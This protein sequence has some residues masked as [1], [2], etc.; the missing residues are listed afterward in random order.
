MSTPIITVIV[1]IFNESDYIDRCMNSLQ[2][3]THR[4]LQ[5]ILVDGGSTDG[6]GQL[7]DKWATRWNMGPD[8]NMGIVEVIH[9]ANKGVSE[10]RNKGLSHAA[11]EYVTFLDGDDWL[12]PDAISKMYSVL[13]SEQVDMAGLS[14]ISRYPGE[15]S[16]EK[17]SD[18]TAFETMTAREFLAGHI[19]KGDVHVWGRLYKRDLIG[20]LRFRKDL[21]I[22][23]DMLFVIEY[24][25]KCDR[26]AHMSYRGYDYFRNPGGTMARPFS[27]SSMDQVKC[28][29]EA[30]LLLAHEGDELSDGPDLR[31]NML[32]SIMLTASRMALLDRIIIT[33]EAH[34]E[35]I[36]TLRAKIKEYKNGA[37]MK[38][39]DRGYRFKVRMFRFFPGLY[40]SLYH[41]HK[42]GK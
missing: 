17:V 8:S 31:A 2:A 28:W 14:F 35:Y 11:G 22:G 38:V 3:Q 9:T 1:P 33:D 32:I 13:E 27:A 18:D 30:R 4:K 24:V 6:S 42:A 12:E 41:R 19:L 40:M 21:T 29:D 23:E 25:K 39:L 20:D 5:I 37:A 16:S 34:K 36:R 10:S 15:E 7:C 26:V